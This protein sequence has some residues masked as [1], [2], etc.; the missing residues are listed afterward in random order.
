MA[1]GIEKTLNTA[2]GSLLEVQN[3][4]VTEEH[5]YAVTVDELVADWG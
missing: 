5:L 3:D 1:H 4:R 2:L